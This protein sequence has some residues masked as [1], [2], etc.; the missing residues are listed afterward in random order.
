MTTVE[1]VPRVLVAGI[2][3]ILLQDDGFGPHAI[4]RLQSQFEI[5][6]NAELLDLGTPALDFV[7]YLAGREVVIL[8]DAL[9]S[10]GEPGDVVVYRQD[11]LRQALPGM[12]LS[13]HQPCLHETLF[14]A[15]A[16]GVRFK[17]TMLIGVV[18][19][20]F[21]VDTELSNSMKSGM[22]RALDLVVTVLARN[23]VRVRRRSKP[24][25]QSAW[26]SASRP[27]QSIE[28]R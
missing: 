7:D 2:G 3:N 13:A 22:T 18:G 25:T 16:S 21:D 17:E 28:N 9:S 14:A 15:E 19:S 4:A 8:L 27:F 26:W 20:S 1:R 10:G 11:Q 23:G 5:G 24:L 6:G 12:R